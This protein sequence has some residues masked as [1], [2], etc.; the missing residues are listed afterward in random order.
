MKKGIVMIMALSLIMV[1]TLAILKST[2]TTENYLNDMSDTVFN[3]QFNRTFLDMTSIIKNAT[4]SI[5]DSDA[6]SFLVQMPLVISDDKT[7]LQGVMTLSSAG[8]K[9]NINN[10]INEDENQTVNQ[11][12]YDLFSSIASNY[13]VSD[14]V[15]L[16]SIILD[17]IDK[18][19]E[20]RSFGS[21][22]SYQDNSK[23]SDGGI[24]NKVAF[25]MILDAYAKQA[26]DENAYSIPWNDFISY[27]GKK[28]DYNYINSKIKAILEKD[29]GINIP[30]NNSLIKKDDDLSLDD[31]QKQIFKNLGIR[32]YVPRLTCNFKFFYMDKEAEIDFIYDLETKRISSIE[33]IF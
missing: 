8:G 20:E 21:E 31:E 33:T 11:P 22:L 32:Y 28:I 24:P 2:T 10:L 9:F 15:L 5:K 12:L 26:R 7:S 29:Y 3:A 1:L 23:I 17:T 25:K 18:D 16:M 19:N 27:N 30:Y 6:F 13:H 14:S 4:S